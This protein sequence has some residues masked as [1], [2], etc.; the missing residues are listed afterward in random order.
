MQGKKLQKCKKTLVSNM[1]ISREKI[2]TQGYQLTLK[3]IQLFGISRRYRT[4]YSWG[5]FKF[6]SIFNDD[7]DD[8]DDDDDNDD[9]NDD[10]DNDDD[11]DD[12]AAAAAADDDDNDDDDDNNNNNNNNNTIFFLENVSFTKHTPIRKLTKNND[13]SN[14]TNKHKHR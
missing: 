13:Q 6:G 1:V 2:L 8:D 12:D 10:D 9:D 5:I 11:D 4:P 7:D 14:Y 3:A